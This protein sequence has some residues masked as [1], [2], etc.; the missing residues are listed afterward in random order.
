[1]SRLKVAGRGSRIQ[2]SGYLDGFRMGLR[3]LVEMEAK[4]N[5]LRKR[6]TGELAS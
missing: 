2:R 6:E 4:M 5:Y 3:D 1:M